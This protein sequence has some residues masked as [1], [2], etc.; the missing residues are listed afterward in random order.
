MR[1][2]FPLTVQSPDKLT[3]PATM[4][5]PATH[6]T[7]AGTTNRALFIYSHPSS[8]SSF[9]SRSRVAPRLNMATTCARSVFPASTS[10][11]KIAPARIFILRVALAGFLL[12]P[13][14]DLLE[15]VFQLLDLPPYVLLLHGAFFPPVAA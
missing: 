11:S 15:A 6:A 12:L 13:L 7:N 10:A 8:C 1:P 2:S 4:R 5:Q 14:V 3:A 9:T